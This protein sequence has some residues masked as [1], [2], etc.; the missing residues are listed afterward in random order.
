MPVER[1]RIANVASRVKPV[2]SEL[3]PVPSISAINF[4]GEEKR[5]PGKIPG[6]AYFAS[7]QS[8]RLVRTSHVVLRDGR[9]VVVILILLSRVH[10]S[11]NALGIERRATR[12]RSVAWRIGRRG[13]AARLIGLSQCSGRTCRGHRRCGVSGHHMRCA[14]RGGMWRGG[15]HRRSHTDRQC[16]DCDAISNAF[17]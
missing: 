10:G 4:S 6:F 2:Q 17:H 15:E 16:A 1:R 12:V 11:S 9:G 5:S 3:P 14:G 8:P 13:A 7:I